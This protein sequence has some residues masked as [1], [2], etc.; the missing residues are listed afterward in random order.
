MEH[1]C[2]QLSFHQDSLLNSSGRYRTWTVARKPDTQV[3]RSLIHIV[4]IV[5]QAAE[6]IFLTVSG[7]GELCKGVLVNREATR[8]PGQAFP[9]M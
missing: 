2:F 6:M 9:R 4:C 5:V 3:V 7:T 1:C 8:S